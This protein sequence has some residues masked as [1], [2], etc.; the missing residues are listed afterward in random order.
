MGELRF[1]LLVI[2]LLRLLPC[3]AQTGPAGVQNSAT[4]VFWVK[5]DAGTSSTVNLTAISSWSDQSGNGINVAQTTAASQPSFASNIINGF[6][7]VQFDNVNGNN[8]KM[9]APDNSLLDNTTGYT[10]FMVT[11]PLVLD[12]AARCVVS[13]R[14]NVGVDQSFMHFYYTS[15]NFYTD[16]QTTN[17]RY[18][19]ATA[20]SINTNY[21]VTQ[22]FDGTLASGSRCKTYIGSALNV[23][24][25]ETST[26]VPDNNS[27]LLLGST[28]ANDPRPYGGYI[29]E[30]IIYR[31]ALTTA[32]RVI[33]ENYLS[34][35]YNITLSANDKYAGDNSGNGD[36]DF[37]V[38]GVGQ[39][40]TGSSTSFSASTCAGLGFSAIS[41]LDNGDYLLAGHA[42]TT[43][44]VITT[45]VGGFTGTNKSRWQRI[46]YLDVTNSSTALSGNITFDFSD[47]GLVSPTLGLSQDY[48]LLY[49]SG[50]S[51]NWT[52]LTTA[53]SISGDQILFDNLT[54]S[55]DGYY[56]LGT[57]NFNAS[58][59]PIKLASFEVIVNESSIDI[60]WS[61]SLEKN[62]NRF[63]LQSADNADDFKTFETIAPKGIEGGNQYYS[64][65]DNRQLNGTRYYRLKTIDNDRTYE[66]SSVRA[67]SMHWKGFRVYPKP[68]QNSIILEGLP[69][70]EIE[71]QVLD[72]SGK[73]FADQKIVRTISDKAA[74]MDFS[75]FPSGT[76]LLYIKYRDQVRVEKI[77]VK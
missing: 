67:A 58:P 25:S 9:T 43:N 5:A 26:L 54:I 50:T 14:T 64:V 46:W 28:D 33:V 49:R 1:L 21:I 63:E 12:G 24:A 3:D 29:A 34:S 76:Y 44:S 32:P 70:E 74:T 66:Y 69:V 45:D 36:Y 48:V 20:F 60:D 65:N 35:K 27:P 19:T 72:A 42:T 47:A 38:A 62:V 23:T 31:T 17:D 37:D 77:P 68:T 30:V 41:G 59:L 71:I 10:F 61:T 13:K 2:L 8:D 15:N 18:S 39:E 6:P 4:C 7:A 73:F 22:Q 55:N 16:I 56:T 57:K 52:E 53:S 40:S 11:R 51:G 75:S